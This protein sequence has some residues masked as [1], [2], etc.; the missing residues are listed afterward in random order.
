MA[1]RPLEACCQ[2][3]QPAV[4]GA[5]VVHPLVLLGLGAVLWAAGTSLQQAI[6]NTTLINS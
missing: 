4:E 5:W 6:T 3:M 1:C 2:Q